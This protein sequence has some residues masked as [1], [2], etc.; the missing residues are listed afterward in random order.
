M[1]I[2]EIYEYADKIGLLTFSTIVGDEVHSRIAHLNGYDDEGI[3]F[4]TRFAYGGATYN[5]AG[6][7]IDPDKCISCGVCHATCSFDAIKLGEDG[8][9]S[10]IP[11]RC[12]DCGSCLLK[13]PVEAIL[14]SLTF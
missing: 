9:Y 12:D 14:P 5:P 8:K 10:V 7:C 11:E 4:R 3:Y 6:V 13:C 1:T 2:A